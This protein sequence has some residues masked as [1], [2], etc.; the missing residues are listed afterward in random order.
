MQPH[1]LV[2]DD[3]PAVLEVLSAQLSEF[4]VSVAT[5]GASAMEQVRRNGFDLV[6]ADV[7]MPGMD[8]VELLENVRKLRPEVVR[9]ILTG[10]VDTHADA[11]AQSRN[12]VYTFKK[13][14]GEEL[15]TAVRRALESQET[16]RT[17]RRRLGLVL[18]W[19]EVSA[20]LEACAGPEE[21]LGILGRWLEGLEGVKHV[22]CY[23]LRRAALECIHAPGRLAD[24]SLFQTDNPAVRCITEGTIAIRNEDR[25]ESSRCLG[26]GP[27]RGVVQW[28]ACEG[29]AE[30]VCMVNHALSVTSLAL[31]AQAQGMAGQEMR[32]EETQLRRFQ[33]LAGMGKLLAIVTH[34][35]ASPL[36]AMMGQMDALRAAIGHDPKASGR[37]DV[38]TGQ[39]LRISTILDRA[40]QVSRP[41]SQ[42]FATVEL[43]ET[44]TTTVSLVGHHYRTF[45]VLI[46]LEMPDSEVAVSASAGEL[47]QVWLNLLSNALEAI[48]A[49]GTG[50][51]GITIRVQNRKEQGEVE[52]SIGDNGVGMTPDVLKR[53]ETAPD[54]FTTRPDGMGLGVAESRRIVAEHLGSLSYSSQ[55]GKGTTAT[56]RLST[57]G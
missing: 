2:V 10:Y 33:Q 27:S 45:G 49:K 17:L 16:M 14:W 53:I 39:L 43:T 25:L 52:V 3:D 50:G 23:V 8:G 26:L 24:I 46:T 20:A 54:F 4:H 21:T 48:L 51:G 30:T 6:I 56:V 40:R 19:L 47:Q 7:R 41:P 34:E 22:G 9:F 11:A 44:I 1:I 36:S 57:L 13:P 37:L 38:L 29:D 31:R 18:R 32:P 5:S 55:S 42:E 35:I 15:L 12:G 28:S